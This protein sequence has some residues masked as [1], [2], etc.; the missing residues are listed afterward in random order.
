M[1][2]TARIMPVIAAVCIM[3]IPSAVQAGKWFPSHRTARS[4]IG[5][6]IG[7]N[8]ASFAQVDHLDLF[9]RGTVPGIPDEKTSPGFGCGIFGYIPLRGALGLRF[10]IAYT[11]KGGEYEVTDYGDGSVYTFRFRTAYIENALL[12]EVRVPFGGLHTGAFL[13]PYFAR[14]MSG[15]IELKHLGSNQYSYFGNYKKFDYGVTYGARLEIPL[16]RTVL[17]CDVR[18]SIGFTDIL[19]KPIRFTYEE[20]KRIKPNLK[21]SVLALGVGISL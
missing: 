19:E 17:L 18:F 15:D 3:M 2:K 10:E 21:N 9:Q 12:L 20:W 6:R 5:L 16:G 14:L 8:M 1:L 11:T 7:Y 4:L 13:G